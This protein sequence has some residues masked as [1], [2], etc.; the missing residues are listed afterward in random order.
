MPNDT[1]QLLVLAIMATAALGFVIEIAKTKFWRR[2]RR[3]NSV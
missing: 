2:W 3:Y 1:T